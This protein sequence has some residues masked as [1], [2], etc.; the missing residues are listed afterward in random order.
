MNHLQIGTALTEP[1]S[2]GFW[3]VAA[4]AALLVLQICSC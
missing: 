4:S 1:Q 3:R 2:V